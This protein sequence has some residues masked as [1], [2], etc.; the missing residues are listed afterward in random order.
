MLAFLFY[1]ITQRF[2]AFWASPEGD[3]CIAQS[4]RDTS[5]QFF[6]MLIRPHPGE[7]AYERGFSMIDMPD[8][9]DINTGLFQSFFLQD[10]VAYIS[11][12]IISNLWVDMIVTSVEQSVGRHIPGV[13][14]TETFISY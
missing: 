13:L 7:R 9:A 6:A 10:Y 2:F 12:P 1:G 5:F 14:R 11:T 8:H 3:I 4:Y